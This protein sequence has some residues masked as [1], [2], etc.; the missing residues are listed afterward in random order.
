MRLFLMIFLHRPKLLPRSICNL[1]IHIRNQ[2]RAQDQ[3][4]KRHQQKHRLRQKPIR[5]NHNS[6]KEIKNI[7]KKIMIGLSALYLTLFTCTTASA[8]GHASS[9][10]GSSSRSNAYGGGSTS[11]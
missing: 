11:H 2:L 4:Q 9:W 5:H 7:M 6:E 8:Y 10:G 3:R 1:L